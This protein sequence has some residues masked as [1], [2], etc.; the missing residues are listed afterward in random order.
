[1]PI[2]EF[3]LLSKWA[4]SFI[5]CTVGMHPVKNRSV[6]GFWY[7]EEDCYT[8]FKAEVCSLHRISQGFRER[9]IKRSL[10]QDQICPLTLGEKQQYRWPNCCA[11]RR[12]SI[13][14]CRWDLLSC[15]LLCDIQFR[16]ALLW[17]P[18]SRAWWLRI[19]L[20]Q[21]HLLLRRSWIYSLTS[22]WGFMS[23]QEF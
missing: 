12:W 1:M 13:K 5:L 23:R 14:L 21:H 20:V 15:P 16:L 7:C 17:N 22:L 18:S 9:S 6:R 4:S 19:H 2:S 8:G 3:Y 11:R 10:L